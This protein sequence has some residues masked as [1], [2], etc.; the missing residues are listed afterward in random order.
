MS[1]VN[2]QNLQSLPKISACTFP[3]LAF[4]THN[5]QD[6]KK[7]P[8]THVQIIWQDSKHVGNKKNY[9]AMDC[10]KL[11]NM[12]PENIC[13]GSVKL[14][15][16]GECWFGKA[17]YHFFVRNSY[18]TSNCSFCFGVLYCVNCVWI[19]PCRQLNSSTCTWRLIQSIQ[20]HKYTSNDCSVW[21]FLSF[22]LP[23]TFSP[24]NPL[25]R[26]TNVTEWAECSLFCIYYNYWKSLKFYFKSPKKY[27]N[28][29]SY[30]KK[31]SSSRFIVSCIY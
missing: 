4:F 16:Y 19:S 7:Q 18:F 12:K 31:K 9:R 3:I 8:R 15:N 1:I 17:E 27:F 29:D 10:E 25:K 11:T 28:Q 13:Y 22:I 21:H 23:I 20:N 26:N 30:E 5:T 14:I 24:L 2:T 6:N